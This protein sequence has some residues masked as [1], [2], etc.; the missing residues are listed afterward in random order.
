M[1]SCSSTSVGCI[2]AE[3]TSIKPLLPGLKEIDQLNR[4]FQL[5]GTPSEADWPG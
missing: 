1:G 4:I 2:F 3:L 5:C